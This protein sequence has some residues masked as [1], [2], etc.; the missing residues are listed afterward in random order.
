[1]KKP[2]N[3]ATAIICLT[4]LVLSYAYGVAAP[5]TKSVTCSIT[6]YVR[7]K[8]DIPAQ[9]GDLPEIDFSY[10]SKVTVFSFRDRNFLVI[11]VDEADPSRIR[12]VISAQLKKGKG[13]YDGQFVADFGGHQLQLD[14]GPV[15]CTTSRG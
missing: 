2:G 9:L 14:N 8:F 5:P 7:L 13:T 10:P 1:M 11:A 15:S 4:S 6:D 12:I 3:R